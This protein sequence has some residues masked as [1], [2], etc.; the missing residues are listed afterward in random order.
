M[1]VIYR[2]RMNQLSPPMDE[3]L[4]RL[5][6]RPPE[7]IVDWSR[8]KYVGPSDQTRGEPVLLT[9][10]EGYSLLEPPNDSHQRMEGR[11]LAPLKRWVRANYG[12]QRR[13]GPAV[14]FYHGRPWR[15]WEDVLLPQSE[16][17]N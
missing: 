16:A 10:P 3:L 17:S 2:G 1:E 11:A 15:S 9:S 6:N 4:K 8:I 13:E 7:V 5:E 12:G 14:L